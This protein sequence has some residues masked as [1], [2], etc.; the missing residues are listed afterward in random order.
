MPVDGCPPFTGWWEHEAMSVDASSSNPLAAH[1][2]GSAEDGPNDLRAVSEPFDVEPPYDA[3]APDLQ[4]D[5][6]LDREVS[7]L[8]FNTRVLELAEDPTLPLLERVRFLAIFA[9]NLD[10]FFMV[11]VAGLKRR[12]AAGVAVPAASGLMPRE[13]L[14]QIWA[15]TSSL[16]QRQAALFRD[17]IVPALAKESIEL[18]RWESLDA[19]E[20]KACKK[21]FKNRVFP[22]LTPLA[23]DPAHPFPYISGLSLNLAV[24]VRNPKTGKEHFAR[25]KVPP[26]FSRFVPV[27]NQRFVPLEDVIG[28]HLKR[29][30]PGMEVLG[31]HT[32]RVTRNE[33]LEV[34]ED[35]A[36]NLLAAL[37]KE[38]LRRRFGPPVRLEVEESIDDHILE[39]L[40]SELGISAGEVVRLPG[41]LDLTGL[42]DIADIDRAELK[43]PAF[44]PST[45]VQ[46]AEVETASPVDVFKA[47]QRNDVLLHHPY[48]SFSTSVQR[49]I[50]QAADDPHVLAIKQTLYRTSGDSPIVEALIDAAEAGKQVLVLVEIKARFDEQANIKWA[51]KLEHAGCHVVY[52][53]VGLKTHCKLAMVVRDEPDGI[54]RYV[55]IGTGNYNPKTARVY[56]DF[57]LLTAH[58]GIGED[59]AHLFNNLSGFSRNASYENLLVAPDSVR[60]GLIERIR[61]EVEHREAGRPARIRIKANSIVDEAVIDELYRASMAGVPVDLLTRGICAARPGVPGLS[62]TMRV[63]SVLGRFLEHSRICWFENGGTPSAWIGS[64]DLMHR[65]LD[66]R[67]ECLVEL[68][69]SPQVEEV[70]RLLD[71]AFDDRTASW[72]LTSDGTWVRHHEDDHGHPLRDLQENLIATNR[73]RRAIRPA[74]V[75]AR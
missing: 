28:E 70:G 71:L 36:E 40:V 17:E 73:R 74:V 4:A 54:R 9:S 43:Y 8:H 7:W 11:R 35:D 26:I 25:V 49:F 61:A 66:R 12:I 75:P 69:G 31:V 5:R 23:V 15:T 1:V 24:L 53:L 38:L 16:M 58:E 57:G 47:V 14:E 10:E 44:V 32:F 55:H 2:A 65:N 6:F 34:E 3:S 22:V 19:D 42:Y 39:L 27:G 18:V 46:L 62:E 68:P 64:A 48:D 45:H 29:L 59:V 41:P 33:D 50:E 63:R 52:G 30:F 21:L 51:R 67:V 37:E 13:V 72:W 20:Q 60:T 56:E